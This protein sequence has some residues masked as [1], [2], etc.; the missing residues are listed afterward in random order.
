ML[1]INILGE[2][3]KNLSRDK[4]RQLILKELGSIGEDVVLDKS[5]R[6]KSTPPMGSARS[7]MSKQHKCSV[8][9]YMYEK[10]CSECGAM[11]EDEQLA[12]N[13][14]D[15]AQ[16][17]QCTNCESKNSYPLPG[18]ADIESIDYESLIRSLMGMHSS[19]I[20]GVH[21]HDHHISHKGAYMA[22]SQMF[23]V[24]KYA[25]KLYHMI[26]DGHNLEDWMR[27]KLAQISD[28][29]SEVYHA[30]EHDIHEGDL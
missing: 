4:L 10:D 1:R 7:S 28:D 24:A 25:Q 8:H 26:P 2:I 19:A 5:K 23:K 16:C 15:C 30:L 12:I 18:S 29:I 11:Y 13:E 20:A 3:M 17:G 27:T 22:K 14:S 9:G 21:N 6:N